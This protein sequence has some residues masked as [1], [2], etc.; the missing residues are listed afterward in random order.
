MVRRPRTRAQGARPAGG[1]DGAASRRRF[2]GSRC[3]ALPLLRLP[4]CGTVVR[5]VDFRF[6][7]F[8]DACGTRQGTHRAHDGAPDKGSR[9]HYGLPNARAINASSSRA[10]TR[11]DATHRSWS[12]RPY[13]YADGQPRVKLEKEIPPTPSRT[14][15]S[16]PR[17][18]SSV[19]QAISGRHVE[20]TD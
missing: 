3:C 11:S 9:P 8:R 5:C 2:G 14:R 10:T 6:C 19:P 17:L 1:D 7:G 16:S 4:R 12:F 15:W 20:R 13:E 18:G